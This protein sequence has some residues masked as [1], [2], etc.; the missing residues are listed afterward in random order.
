MSLLQRLKNSFETQSSITQVVIVNFVFFLT[1]NVV[2]NI[3]H[4]DLLTYT[5]LPT[6]PTAFLFKFWT[7]F[8]YM[9]THT[10]FWHLLWNMILFYFFAQLFLNLMA[11]RKLIYLYVLSGLCGGALVLI[12]SMAFAERFVGSYLI[13]A[14]AAVLGVGACM[15]IFSP[16]YRVFLFGV[17]EMPFKYVYGII[18]IL[19]TLVDLSIN[20]GGKLSHLGGALFGLFYG[21]QL[22]DGLDLFQFSLGSRKKRKLKIVH[23]SQERFSNTSATKAVSDDYRLNVLLDK[24]SKSGYDSLSKSE[25]EELFQLSQ[26][27]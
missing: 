18:F 6:T 11:P 25:K 15:A 21:Y 23:P 13:G 16:D 27:K 17:I 4:L 26:K 3:S 24:I 7:V 22:K 10:D 1:V 14:S 2:G 20:T 5:A 12:M 8:T 9:F 19:S